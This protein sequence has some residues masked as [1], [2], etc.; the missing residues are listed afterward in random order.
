[1]FCGVAFRGRDNNSK[2]YTI[3][4]CTVESLNNGRLGAI[5]SFTERGCPFFGNL[6][7]YIIEKGPQSV[8]FIERFFPIIW[9]FYCK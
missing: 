1:M 8:Y 9:S 3:K 4:F 7:V 2:V 6:L 5:L